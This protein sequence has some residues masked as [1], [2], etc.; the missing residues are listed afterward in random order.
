MVV[1]AAMGAEAA[2]K[3]VVQGVALGF[4]APLKATRRRLS[5]ACAPDSVPCL[6]PLRFGTEGQRENAVHAQQAQE[7]WRRSQ[8]SLYGWTGWD[9]R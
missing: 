8:M 9:V 5:P 3:R 7:Q 2:W 4:A 1:A 6:L